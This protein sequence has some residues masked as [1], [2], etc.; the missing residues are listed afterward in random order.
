MLIQWWFDRWWRE[1][2]QI[3]PIHVENNFKMFYKD[4][5]SFLNFRLDQKMNMYNHGFH[6]SI[7]TPPAVR[8]RPNRYTDFGEQ[9]YNR[10]VDGHLGHLA[11]YP[12]YS[13]YPDYSSTYTSEPKHN[14]KLSDYVYVPPAKQKKLPRSPNPHHIHH[15]SPAPSTVSSHGQKMIYF[16]HWSS[17]GIVVQSKGPHSET[18][19]IFV[20][21][22]SSWIIP[23][24]G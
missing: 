13:F 14:A 21:Q 1:I 4:N 6:H 22:F 11:N 12:D 16:K 8:A 23:S 19:Q 24:R 2:V 18:A 15:S 5:D 20:V 3:I 9:D 7:H 17:A 10:S